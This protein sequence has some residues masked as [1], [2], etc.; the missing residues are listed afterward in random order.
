VKDRAFLPVAVYAV[1]MAFL[2]A[3]CVVTLK[4]LYY[5]E[6]W[7]PPFHAFPASG[8][9]LEQWR[10]VATLVMLA[11]VAA[12]G[13]GGVIG[14]LRRGLWA[15]GIWDLGYYFFL[16]LLTGY[17]QRLT[18]P[19]VVFL[20]PVPWVVAVWVPVTASTLCLV[21]ALLLTGKRR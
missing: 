21:A 20:V 7:H 14:F 15:F 3:A 6:G 17:P 1:A 13:R 2:E 4:R 11:I 19:D 18:D 12:L 10:E 16:R 5:P 8:L 9:R